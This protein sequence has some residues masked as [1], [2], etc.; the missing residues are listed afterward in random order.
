M[1]DSGIGRAAVAALLGIGVAIA[2]PY[3][4]VGVDVTWQRIVML[5]L[6]LACVALLVA[7][8]VLS[9][10]AEMCGRSSRACA[11]RVLMLSDAFVISSV[12]A[13]LVT[14]VFAFVLAVIRLA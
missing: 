5:S 8:V 4:L 11:D 13:I 10:V 7:T 12:G 3:A 14:C 1:G 2:G 6:V 9:M